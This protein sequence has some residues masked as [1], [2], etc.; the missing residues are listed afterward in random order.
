[1][2]DHWSLSHGVPTSYGDLGNPTR[3][4]AVAIFYPADLLHAPRDSAHLHTT[5]LDHLFRILAKSKCHERVEALQANV[6]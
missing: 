1:M 4:G 3:N 5:T 2:C 6:A